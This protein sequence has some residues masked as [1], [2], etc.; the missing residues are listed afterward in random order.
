VLA[1]GTIL[2]SRYRIIQ[3][4][5]EGGMGTVYE[6]LDQRLNSLVA[7]KETRV[8]TDE[9]RRAFEHEASLLA[10][11][12]HR[13]LPSVID[14]FA[15]NESQYLVMKFI[16]GEDLAQM[17]DRRQRS[18]PLPDVLAWADEILRALEYLHGHNPPILHRDIKPSNL[19]LTGEGELFLLDFGLAKGAAGQ[20][21][22]LLTSR[23]LKGYTPVYAPLE[24]IHGGGTDPRSDLYAVGATLYH[25]LTG[26]AP[27][28]APTRFVAIDDEQPDPLRPADEINQDVP[29]AI[30]NI[31]STAMAMNRRYRPN[32]AA[33]MRSMLQEITSAIHPESAYIKTTDHR[34]AS[35]TP[36]AADIAPT[37]PAEVAATKPS[38]TVPAS[39]PI[40]TIP[41]PPPET[42]R[43]TAPD[44]AELAG[45]RSQSPKRVLAVILVLIGVV[46]LAIGSTLVAPALLARLKRSPDSSGPLAADASPATMHEQIAKPTV[47]PVASPTPSSVKVR[48]RLISQGASGCSTYDGIRVTLIT[49]NQTFRA[50]TNGAGFASFS[51]VPCG[52]VAKISAPEVQLQ[53]SA[54]RTFSISRA[55]ECTSNEVFLGSYG[56]IKGALTSERVANS[57]FKPGP[58]GP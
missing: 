8:T 15:E 20:M 10:N 3:Q 19:K 41:A 22:T 6:A 57:C 30:A 34:A 7:I 44:A 56:D 4:L 55:I 21:P 27:I 37:K 45:A 11:L 50:T 14:H 12:R 9:A 48:L 1:P 24:Q 52:D 49:R 23:S 18:F 31:I 36:S 46:L 29:H 58:N 28:D 2:Q 5:G 42:S 40:R 26:C 54:G 33:E 32:S 43:D 51:D 53:M 47:T 13:T 25:L 39:Q 38:P 16:P 35:L 17:L